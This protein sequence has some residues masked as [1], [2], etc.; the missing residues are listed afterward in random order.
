VAEFVLGVGAGQF[1]LLFSALGLGSLLSA[2]VM[3][4]IRTPTA[5]VLLVG[6][7]IFTVLFVAMALS[8]SYWLTAALLVALGASGLAFTT[9]ANVTLQLSVPDE[10]R[11]RI[12]SIYILLFAGSTPIGAYFTGV[13]SDWLGVATALCVD[14]GL[15]ALG[16]VLALAYRRW[17]TESSPACAREAEAA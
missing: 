7:S 3:A 5:R 12:L 14:A 4:G 8:Q 1:G 17:K 10:Y 15:C 13:M 11:G 16:I 6:S 9:T 2:A